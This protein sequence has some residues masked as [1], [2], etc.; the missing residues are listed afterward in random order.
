MKTKITWWLVALLMAIGAVVLLQGKGD[1]GVAPA[2]ADSRPAP[3]RPDAPAGPAGSPAGQP[4]G[5]APARGQPVDFASLPDHAKA[6]LIL[7]MGEDYHGHG[8]LV[9]Y[10]LHLEQR[11]AQGDGDA[12]LPLAQLFRDCA[13]RADMLGAPEN[14]ADPA[15]FTARACAGLPPRNGDYDRQLVAR[16]ALRGVESA[17]LAEFSFAPLEVAYSRDMT[18]RSA[19]A[20]DVLGRL[21]QLSR[22]GHPEASWQLANA[23]VDQDFGVRDLSQAAQHFRRFLDGIPPEDPRQAVARDRLVRI[24]SSG[25]LDPDALRACG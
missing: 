5:T 4:A 13:L 21:G 11:V 6:S 22:N 20:R 24:C 25:Q 12:V 14:P 7:G 18:V 17:V 16:E 3:E 2:V 1:D 10:F 9:G 19:W 8:S 23:Y 15:H